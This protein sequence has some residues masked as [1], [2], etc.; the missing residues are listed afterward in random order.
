MIDKLKPNSILGPEE[1]DEILLQGVVEQEQVILT[2][3]NATGTV[4]T[5]V[6]IPKRGRGRPRKD[7][8]PKID[9]NRKYNTKRQKSSSTGL[10]VKIE[11]ANQFREFKSAHFKGTTNSEVLT[12]LMATYL[13]SKSP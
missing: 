5:T 3:N 7:P 11:V 8:S 4:V 10:Q 2:E 9:K 1:G 13:K 12:E 6:L